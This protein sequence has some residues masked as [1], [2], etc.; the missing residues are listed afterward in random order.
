M[1]SAQRVS[2]DPKKAETIVNWPQPTNIT[3][4]RSFLEL[5][6][7]YWKFV[8]GFSTIAMPLIRLTQKRAKFE[9]TDKCETSFQNLKEKLVSTPV[10]TLSFGTEWFVIYSDASKNSLGCVFMQNGRV[11]TY[12]SH[13]LKSYEQNYPTHD[14][15]LAAVVFTLKIWRHYLYGMQCE[16]FTNHK[17]LK[18]LF[19][20]KELNM[21]QKGG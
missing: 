15:E 8:E 18:Y 19:N 6:G 4:V 20:Q 2:V 12:A 1:I 3:E 14:L 7:Y 17:S 21:R 16:I 5:A 11:I 13:Q 10:L 9:W